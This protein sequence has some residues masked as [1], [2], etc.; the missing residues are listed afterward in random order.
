MSRR[1]AASGPR[2]RWSDGAI[3]A[4][5]VSARSRAGR[6]GAAVAGS[7]GAAA[8]AL[9]ILISLLAGCTPTYDWR[10]VRGTG[11]PFTVLLP[12]KP[13]SM[14]R[15]VNLG[16]IT[17]SM[18]MTAAEVDHVTFAVG[19]AELASAD[20][21]RAALGVMKDTMVR[22][23]GGV[24]LQEKN[25]A[26]PGGQRIDVDAGPAGSGV[27]GTTGAPGSP[28]KPG[29]PGTPAAPTTS[30]MPPTNASMLHARF[31]AHERRVYQVMVIGP[32]KSMKTEAVDTFLTSF[33][34]E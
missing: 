2:L 1:P 23:I 13:A 25:I 4:G 7:I 34:L 5:F 17:A 9:G 33:T 3:G 16:G 29:S 22:N 24:V 31:I 32:A 6:T 21:A 27:A 28:G 18:T 14:T 8:A 30:T 11:I 26:E 19:T 20:Q 12:A 15:S 10:T